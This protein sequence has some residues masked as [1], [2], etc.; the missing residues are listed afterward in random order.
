MSSKMRDKVYLP[1]V[2][3]Q[4]LGMLLLDLVPLYPECLWRWPSSPLHALV[5]LRAWWAARSGDPYFAT[6]THE[7]WFE[8]FLYVEALVQLPLTLYLVAELASLRPTSGAA[9]LAGLAYGCVTFMGAIACC[10]DIWRMGPDR[11]RDEHWGKL[12]WGTYLPFCIIP[13]IMAVD[14]YLRL[15][16]RVRTPAGQANTP[17]RA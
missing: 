13:G 17:S 16:P 8:A 2:G 10:C 11:V 7:P 12:F 5:S 6:A 3:T 4:L 9:E 1:I 14:M 15:L